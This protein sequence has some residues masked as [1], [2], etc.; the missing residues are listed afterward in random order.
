MRAAS[1]LLTSSSQK[2]SPYLWKG[3]CDY[4]S[5]SLKCWNVWETVPLLR[6]GHSS[7]MPG[8]HCH[9]LCYLSLHIA[10]QTAKVH[11]DSHFTC[12]D[13]YTCKK[14][15][16]K[17]Y[18]LE[19][20]GTHQFISFNDRAT[21]K[22]AFKGKVSE[23]RRDVKDKKASDCRLRWKSPWTGTFPVQWSELE[24]RAWAVQKSLYR[25]ICSGEQRDTLP[26][27]KCMARSCQPLHHLELLQHLGRWRGTTPHEEKSETLFMEHN[28][29]CISKCTQWKQCQTLFLWAPKSLQMV[30]AAMKLK[31]AYS[32]EGKLWP[33]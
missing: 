30:T 33:T 8:R 31:D 32:L 13:I 9:G 25:A 10:M 23:K 16:Q 29:R 4:G 6:P 2:K 24:T 3:A 15:N 21:Q 17:A 5:H 7:V 18:C 27:S 19:R 12:K 26:L 20:L 14:K 28:T 11:A 22:T 1:W